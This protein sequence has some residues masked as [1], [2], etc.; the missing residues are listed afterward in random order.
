MQTLTTPCKHE[1]H[2]IGAYAKAGKMDPTHTTTL[3]NA[4]V[5]EMKWRYL[6]FARAIKSAIDERDCFGLKATHILSMAGITPPGELA[7][8]FPRT[9]QKMAAF[10][11]W[12]QTQNKLFLESKGVWTEGIELITAPQLGIGVENVWTNKYIHSAYQ[13]G[14]FRARQEM[15]KVGYNVPSIGE[16]GGLGVALNQPMHIDRLG[17]VYSR[18]YEELKGINAS[19]SS[20]ISRVLAQG[21]AEGRNPRELAVLLAST[22]MGPVG[23]LGITDTLGRFIPAAR[24]AEIM[25]RTEII[26]AHHV[27]T[28]QEYKNWGLEGVMVQA[29]WATVG[30]DRVCDECASLEG[31][32]F[33]LEEIESMIPRHP[34]CRCIALPIEQKDV[35]AK[36]AE[37]EKLEQVEVKEGDRIVP[38]SVDSYVP[39]PPDELKVE[40]VL[41]MN[42]K[43]LRDRVNGEY[44]S[45]Y[46]PVLQSAYNE[47][48]AGHD[49]SSM[50]IVWGIRYGKAPELGISFN[51][52]EGKAERGLSLAQEYGKKEIGSS[53]WFKDRKAYEYRGIKIGVGSDGETIILPLHVENLDG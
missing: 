3:R 5:R 53:M 43:G 18:A 10:M 50:P 28:I 7:F 12:I 11:D 23:G 30:D 14:I 19:M 16:S 48:I 51:Y 22:V 8:A 47:G 34:Q 41:R 27:A 36:K 45:F 6:T 31:K 25:A 29:E 26:R 1:H 24:R 52:A 32:I 17:L 49:L 42:A 2:Q 46:T 33:T 37:Q 4:F 38:Y 40:S 15:K 21:M 44:Q 39:A 35:D 20:Q 13:K 9:S